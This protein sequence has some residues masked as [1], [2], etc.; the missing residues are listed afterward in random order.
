MS[1]WDSFKTS[2]AWGLGGAF[3]TRLGW[4]AGGLV[5]RWIK[6]LVLLVMAGSMAKCAA[7]HLAP[8]ALTAAAVSK[9]AIVHPAS[10]S[11]HNR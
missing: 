2:F 6:R 10:S 3:G 7:F 5:T 9:P 4:A 11:G 1:F 8:N